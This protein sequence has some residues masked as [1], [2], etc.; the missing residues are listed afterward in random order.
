MAVGARGDSPARTVAADKVLC[1]ALRRSRTSGLKI[2]SGVS[3]PSEPP[4]KFEAF[5]RQAVNIRGSM[6][7]GGMKGGEKG[8]CAMYSSNW[9]D[10]A[11]ASCVLRFEGFDRPFASVSFKLFLLLSVLLRRALWLRSRRCS[12]RCS[13]SLFCLRLA[14]RGRSDL[15]DGRREFSSMESDGSSGGYASP[16]LS[17][18]NCRIFFA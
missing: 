13:P 8:K 12:P 9:V 4:E 5:Q 17:P 7:R 10:Y 16:T 15:R 14:L 3:K 1:G 18:K 2:P 11:L 6:E